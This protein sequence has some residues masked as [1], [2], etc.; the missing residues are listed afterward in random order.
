MGWRGTECR[1]SRLPRR[2]CPEPAERSG[3]FGCCC[4]RNGFTSSGSRCHPLAGMGCS[5]P[6]IARA[7]E[8]PLRFLRAPSCTPSSHLS[9]PLTVARVFLSDNFLCNGS[10]YCEIPLCFGRAPI[11]DAL[12]PGPARLNLYCPLSR[13]G[14]RLVTISCRACQVPQRLAF[15]CAGN[16]NRA[17][18]LV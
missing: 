12:R 14:E 11:T 15:L 9:C 5:D 13:T 18:G 2:T 6:R 8:P 4:R 16:K 10:L 1:M 7:V 17:T 3:L